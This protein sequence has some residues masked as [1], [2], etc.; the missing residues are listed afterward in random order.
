MSAGCTNLPFRQKQKDHAAQRGRD[1]FGT[2]TRIS[3]SLLRRLSAFFRSVSD[4]DP[5]AAKLA[6]LIPG[7]G[8][9]VNVRN[10]PRVVIPPPP[11]TFRKYCAQSEK[12]ATSP[13][14]KQITQP[15]GAATPQNSDAHKHIAVP[16]AFCVFW[17]H[18]RPSPKSGKTC[19]S[20][21][22]PGDVCERA[23]RSESSDTTPSETPPVSACKPLC[24]IFLRKPRVYPLSPVKTNVGRLCE[25]LK[26]GLKQRCD[27]NFL[28][29]FAGTIWG[30]K[31]NFTGRFSE[32]RRPFDFSTDKER[33]P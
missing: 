11:R 2:A 28:T 29:I 19:R 6:V 9:F 26:S 10:A 16:K 32:W 7:P 13:S 17:E 14:C 25:E 24:A 3:A 23:E 12:T 18:P 1:A 30:E 15:S 31:P 5:K 33:C 4:Q 8:M 20:D 27:G 22:R 21:T